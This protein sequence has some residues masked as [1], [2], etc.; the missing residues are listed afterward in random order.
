MATCPEPWSPRLTS[1]TCGAGTSRWLEA[2]LEHNR[3]D[4][5]SLWHLH[6]RLLERLDL[7]DPGVDTSA[8]WLALGRQ[9]LREGRRADGWRALRCAV[10]MGQ[11]EAAAAAG[12][13]I[14]RVLARR[15]RPAAAELLLSQLHD[16]MPSSLELTVARA[17]LLEWRLGRLDLSLDLVESVAAATDH[18]QQALTAR[19]ARLRRRLAKSRQGGRPAPH[20][21][22]LDLPISW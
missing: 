4:V 9:L 17:K 11:G 20:P 1:S 19:A 21:V 6:A 16:T 22:S 15:G 10:D 8:D 5:L 3:Q 18:A 7:A 14:S 2:A 12:L 13:L